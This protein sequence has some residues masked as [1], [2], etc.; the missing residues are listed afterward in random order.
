M[1][2][3]KRSWNIGLTIPWV[4]TSREPTLMIRRPTGLPADE[5]RW[6]WGEF[7]RCAELSMRDGNFSQVKTNRRT[8]NALTGH[9]AHKEAAG[10]VRSSKNGVLHL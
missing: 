9:A 6:E 10:P 5:G 2:W 4:M 1:K 7:M 8:L 3:W